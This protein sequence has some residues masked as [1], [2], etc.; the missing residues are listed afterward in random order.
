MTVL[1]SFDPVATVPGVTVPLHRRVR[2]RAVRGWLA[3]VAVYMTAAFHRSSLG[4][5]GLDA[6]QRFGISSGALSVF[7]LL[8]LGVYAA[9]QVPTGIL[10]DR[11]GPRCLL[12][13]AALTMATAQLMFALAPTFG[14]ALVA[15]TLLGVGDALVFVSLLRYASEHF[16]PRRYAVVIG[17]TGTLGAL[18]SIVATI[19]LSMALGSVGWTPSFLSAAVASA[20]AAGAVWLLIPRAEPVAPVDRGLRPIASYRVAAESVALRVR[21]AWAAPGNASRLLDALRDDVVRR[22][23]RRAVGRALPGGPG[24][25][26]QRRRARCS[27]SASLPAW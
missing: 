6:A 14:M 26:A 10:V 5:A 16:A 22:D 20:V 24:L 8:Q 21:D 7:V 15:R 12:L 25:L 23:V 19:P 11:F 3:A 9:M 27:A 17:L 13:W 1:E 4:V 2:T 18:G